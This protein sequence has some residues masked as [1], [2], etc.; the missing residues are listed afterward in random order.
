MQKLIHSICILI[1]VSLFTGCDTE[2]DTV[3]GAAPCAAN[4]TDR[5]F[6]IEGH[7]LQVKP[8]E[9]YYI[10]PSEGGNFYEYQVKLPSPYRYLYIR[11]SA[12]KKPSETSTY[13]ITESSGVESPEA[14][15]AYLSVET[16]DGNYY[17]S[18]KSDDQLYVTASSPNLLTLD[19]CD[20]DLFH[21]ADYKFGITGR[22]VFGR[23]PLGIYCSND[24]PANTVNI[25]GTGL[26]FTSGDINYTAPH[27]GGN[28]HE[29]R[30]SLP[31]P[32]KNLYIR[33]SA[34]KT[35]IENGTYTITESTAAE[36]P[37]AG[38]AYLTLETEAGVS[39]SGEPGDEIKVL[40]KDSRITFDFCII[41]MFHA[42]DHAFD[43]MDG[44]I[45]PTY[46]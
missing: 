9:I 1:A 42:T 29:F 8:F 32:Y 12:N 23:V 44:R 37:K 33:L 39:Y 21:N 15:Q 43:L 10:G 16:E 45:T 40:V 34:D 4:L 18:G 11:L 26:T 17:Y 28:F 7:T 25:K 31:S 46:N 36:S 22:M 2:P 41:K 5:T 13:S 14:G 20:V 38:F 27:T 35:P 30:V 24:K 19:L 6:I 3:I